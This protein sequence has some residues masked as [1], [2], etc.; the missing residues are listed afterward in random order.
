[1]CCFDIQILQNDD[2]VILANTCV[3]GG[4]YAFCFVV[5]TVKVDSVATFR[6]V[7]QYVMTMLD[8][9]SSDLT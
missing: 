9:S 1:M 8:L 6:C 2:T 7:I 4:N 3:T 5:I